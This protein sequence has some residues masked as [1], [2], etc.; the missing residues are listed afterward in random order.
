MHN[1]SVKWKI[2]I[3]SGLCL[4]ITSIALISFS[5]SNAISSQTTTKELSSQSVVQKSQQVLETRAQLNAVLVQNYFDEALHRAE[6]LA[7]NSEFLKYNAEENFTASD[8]LRGALN[9]MVRRAVQ[10]FSNVKGAYLVYLPNGLDG[11]DSYYHD[12]DYVGSNE[13]GRFASRWSMNNEDKPALTILS[14]KEIKSAENAEK[15]FCP[16]STSSACVS[17]PN[18]NASGDLVSA[19]TVPV[20]NGNKPI[21]FLGIEISLNQLSTLASESDQALFSGAGEVT[22]VSLSE[23]VIASSVSNELIGQ[24]FNSANVLSDELTSFLFGGETTSHW[25]SDESWIVAFSPISVTNQTW[26]IFLEMPRDVVLDDANKLD[27]II[28]AQ[29][30]EG[31]KKELLVGVTLIVIGL[32]V[33]TL[34]A[35][36]LVK[37]IDNMLMRLNDIASGEGDLTQRI[38]VKHQDEIGKLAQ[39]FNMFLDKLQGIIK[40]VVDT[41]SQ[42]VNTSVEAQSSASTT[43]SSSESQFKEVDMVATAS[44]EMTQTAGLVYQNADSAVNAA[45]LAHESASTGKDIIQASANEMESLV[46]KMEHAVPVVD[47]LA[48]NNSNITEILAVIEGISEQTNLLALN[49]AI[50]AARAGEQGRGFAVVADEVRQLASR[51]QD[52]VGEIRDVI[53]RVQIGTKDVVNAINDGNELALSTSTQVAQAVDNLNATFE[54]IA[55]ITDMNSQIVRAAQEQQQVSVE[56]NQSVANIRDLSASILEQAGESEKVGRSIAEL[57]NEQQVLVSQFKV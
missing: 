17:T 18:F 15:Y 10:E 23:S 49:A 19:I 52:S 28:S 50:E 9:E 34:L 44:E 43:R 38:D 27:N 2:T 13:I 53:A 3:L 45:T 54:A 6:M 24:Q 40:Q 55:E 57:S 32:M 46:E 39:S 30:E 5:V 21:G 37:P 42:V 29:L 56:V 12:A 14:E 48:K 7:Q 51:T 36:R 47:E 31:V 26:G 4:I 16:I 35:T 25:N 20:T 8:E 11:E 22:V 1:M 41:T 33:I